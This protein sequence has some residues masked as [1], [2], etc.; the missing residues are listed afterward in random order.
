MHMG[1]HRPLRFDSPDPGKRLIDAEMAR[2][3]HIAERIDD[4]HIEVLEV[5]ER[6][7]GQIADVRRIGDA[8]EAK[9]ER[10]A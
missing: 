6:F 7:L 5:F 10:L 9:A 3:P 2:M 4:P 1:E 8:A